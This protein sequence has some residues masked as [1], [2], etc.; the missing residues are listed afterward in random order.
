MKLF[1]LSDI[2]GRPLSLDM[3][4]NL[5]FDVEDENH[6]IILIGD[7]FDRYNQNHLVYLEILRMKEILQ[8]RLHLC[9]GNHDQFMEQFIDYV[10][11]HNTIGEPIV[12]EPVLMERWLRNGGAITLEQCFNIASLSDNYSQE[13]HDRILEYQRFIK[14]LNDYV[15]IGNTIF[16]HAAIYEDYRCDFWDREYIFKNS[17]LKNMTIVLGHSP[18]RYCLQFPELEIVPTKSNIGKMVQHKTLKN[19]IYIVDNGEGDNIVMFQEKRPRRKLSD[20]NF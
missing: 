8:D 14:S 13:M 7:Y 17:P 5:G 6:H 11:E 16:T 4:I 10:L 12:S 9:K 1:A 2:H 3:F 18:F 20:E 15:E 19:H